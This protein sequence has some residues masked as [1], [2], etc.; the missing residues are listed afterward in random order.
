VE[1]RQ[2]GNFRVVSK[3]GEG[4]MGVV[5]LAEH[6]RIGRK[7]A[8]K[9]VRPDR[10]GKDE[11]I[12]R[13]ATE[14]WA[15]NSI[16]HPNIVEIFDFGTL[17]DGEV[18]IVMEYIDGETLSARLQR[19]GRLSV[20][21]A[22]HLVWQA[23]AGL[24]AAHSK[25]VVHRDLKPDNLFLVPDRSARGHERVKIVDFGIA[26][27]LDPLRVAPHTRTG[28]MLGTPVYASPE[29]LRGRD[30]DHRTDIYSLGLI[31]HETVCGRPPFVS[32]ALGELVNMHLNVAPGSP[33]AL[34]PEVS[35]HLERTIFTALEKERERRFPD[36]AAFA[37]ALTADP[38]WAGPVEIAS[39]P[40]PRT[41]APVPLL[42]VEVNRKAAARA[43]ATSRMRPRWLL[44]AG[45]V[46][47]AAVV[48]AL[49]VSPLVM[50]RTSDPAPPPP[51]KDVVTGPPPRNAPT[52]SADEAASAYLDQAEAFA[53]SG[54]FTS[55]LAVLEKARALNVKTPTLNIRLVRVGDTIQTKVLVGKAQRLLEVGQIDA[56]VEAAKAALDRDSSNAEAI[57]VL[58]S[59]R[60]RRDESRSSRAAAPRGSRSARR[61]PAP[62]GT[63]FISIT[64]VP[65]GAVY[66]DDAM[67]G[68][69]PIRK[70]V[71]AGRHVV[72][73]RAHGYRPL[74]KSV[75]VA[76]RRSLALSFPLIPEARAGAST[77]GTAA[78]S[79]APA[80][81]APPGPAVSTTP[82]TRPP[83]ERVAPPPAAPG[84]PP[85]SPAPNAAA[86]V[87]SSAA[88]PVFSAPPRKS[89]PV[90]SLPRVRSGA[91]RDLAAVLRQVEAQAVSLAGLSPEFARDVT[92]PLLNALGD[93]SEV[94]V[95]P[96]AL[97]YLL[98]RE[99]ALGH[100]KATASRALKDAHFGG[101]LRRLL[102]LPTQGQ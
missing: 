37:E 82:A 91:P 47:A 84:P 78:A 11:A 55:A 53:A 24:L 22:L 94:T 85:T 99:A 75:T 10:S 63:G 81:A 26:K 32:E 58:T 66:L 7:A 54:R 30:I 28:S 68:T 13:F 23:A 41:P 8:I 65:P 5:Y 39:H 74:R 2:V 72:E 34:N 35:E 62:T 71:P 76:A 29:Q 9:F 27:L 79:P 48:T 36:M 33:R 19:E 67:L 21:R 44:P 89:V 45:V 49:V 25:G 61:T 86:A 16:R 56:A 60:N 46:A 6:P 43:T 38:A 80:T 50:R 57:A 70:R 12:E 87:R 98:V 59:V 96:G 1:G 90:P 3:L 64:S 15:A 95:Y 97:Y 100:E 77:G 14:A 17:P 88:G 51:A 101:G 73:V 92:L 69:V 102:D 18:Y 83:A 20:P 40:T 4:G 42:L 52:P 31:L 93:R